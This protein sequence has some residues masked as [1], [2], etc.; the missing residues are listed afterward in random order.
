M[1]PR[2]NIQKLTI[3]KPKPDD[4]DAIVAIALTAWVPIFA[5]FR[6]LLG[7]AICDTVNPAWQ[8][9]KERQIRTAFDSAS[10]V[11]FLVAELDNR[12]VGFVTWVIRSEGKTAEIGNNAV[13]PE[14]Q[15]R[16]I[17]PRLYREVLDR[18]RAESVAV[19]FV[20]TG[21]DEGHAPARR[22]YAKAGFTRS[23]PIVTYYQD[24]RGEAPA[25]T[26]ERDAEAGPSRAESEVFIVTVVGHDRVGIIGRIAISMAEVNINIVDVDQKI[27]ED[28]FVMTM[29]CDLA[30]STIPVTEIRTRLD[31]IGREMGLEITMQ[32]ESIFNTMHRI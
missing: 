5:S 16:G 12:I 22:A 28:I 7:D 2:P 30:G 26:P 9:E 4:L 17:A 20:T 23:K 13:H 15:G 3:R 19:V 21:L 8:E 1:S 29:A 6:R 32:N 11:R 10:G 31:E 27:M 24:L 14:F 18:L 25:D